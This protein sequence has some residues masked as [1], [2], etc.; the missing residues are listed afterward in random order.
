MITVHNVVAASATVGLLG[1]EGDV[2]RMT[3]IP[4]TY[5]CLL[6]GGLAYVVLYGVGF[7]VGTLVLLL[8]IATLVAAVVA[9]RRG[10]APTSEGT[11]DAGSRRADDA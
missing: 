11:V 6:A 8:V 3:I 7:N 1:R 4:T 5:Y 9:G 2:I 10:R